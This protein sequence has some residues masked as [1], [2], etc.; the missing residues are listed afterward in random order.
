MKKKVPL[1]LFLVVLFLLL[2]VL[3]RESYPQRF[4]DRFFSG[5]DQNKALYLRNT[6]YTER[7]EYN[8]LF[9]GTKKI[10]M[11]GDSHTEWMDWSELMQR[12]DIANRGIS[13]DIT[14]GFL[15]RLHTVFALQPEVCVLEGGINDILMRI[16]LEEIEANLKQLVEQLQEKKIKVV[17]C[18]LTF[19]LADR[20]DAE[21]VNRQAAMMN[22]KIIALAKSKAIPVLDL[23]AETSVNGAR[24]AEYALPDGLHFNAKVY[25]LWKEK[26]QVIL[27]EQGI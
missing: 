6:R 15:K 1:L 3:V 8:Q 7:M 24:K 22:K 25:A 20:P 11:F 17:L 4:Y 9:T 21:R 13:G 10:V 12:N 26:L 14:E 19:G 27:Q 18:T 16:P 5:K 2:A 23:N